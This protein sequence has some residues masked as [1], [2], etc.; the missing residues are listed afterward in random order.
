MQDLIVLG[1]IP[2]TNIQ[3]NLVGWVVIAAVIAVII[4]IV[5]RES[6]A[7]TIRFLLIHISLMLATR[8]RFQ[9]A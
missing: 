2:G 7:Q 9:R 1:I 4:Y 8:R 3:I 6:R 5:R